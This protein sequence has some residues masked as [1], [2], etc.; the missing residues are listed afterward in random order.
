MSVNPRT[1]IVTSLAVVLRLS[2][3]DLERW[4]DGPGSP[5]SNCRTSRT[6]GVH[7]KISYTS[8]VQCSTMTSMRQWRFSPICSPNLRP[9]RP[10]NIPRDTTS[11]LSR[12][13]TICHGNLQRSSRYYLVLFS[14]S[15]FLFC[16]FNK[17]KRMPTDSPA[18]SH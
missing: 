11:T 7:K 16:G 14:S 10:H 2:F 4:K 5:C 12:T 8:G 9:N 13:R 18:F 3:R 15:C 1:C 6:N 17:A